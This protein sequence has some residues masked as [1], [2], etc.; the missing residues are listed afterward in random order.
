MWN[1]IGI[2]DI[3]IPIRNGFSSGSSNISPPRFSIYK[4]VVGIFLPLDRNIYQQCSPILQLIQL[5]FFIF[6]T[7]IGFSNAF[8]SHKAW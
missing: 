6:G 4:C 3:G 5:L 1:T 8:R 2:N 7:Q